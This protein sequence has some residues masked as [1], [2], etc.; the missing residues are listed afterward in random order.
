MLDRASPAFME[1]LTAEQSTQ[2]ARHLTRWKSRAAKP[3]A[4]AHSMAQTPE[5][6]KAK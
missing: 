4:P 2:E 1:R 3:A 6:P 5:L